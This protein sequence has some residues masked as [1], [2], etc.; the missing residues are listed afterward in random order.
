M[1]KSVF[2]ILLALYIIL[3]T[4]CTVGLLYR[5]EQLQHQVDVQQM[6]ID[7]YRQLIFNLYPKNGG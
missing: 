7:V 3:Q 4:I 1:A 2:K 6:Q 5:T